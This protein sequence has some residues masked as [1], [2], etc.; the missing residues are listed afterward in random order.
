M[1]FESE[2]VSNGDGEIFLYF[3]LYNAIRRVFLKGVNGVRDQGDNW[4]RDG[5][6]E[7]HGFNFRGK[8]MENY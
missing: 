3:A 1:H 6:D 5:C 7:I 2:T 4:S 8:K